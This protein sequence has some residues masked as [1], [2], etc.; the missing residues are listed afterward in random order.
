MQTLWEGGD[1]VI[2]SSQQLNSPFLNSFIYTEKSTYSAK[3]L[4]CT[5]NWSKFS[6]ATYLKGRQEIPYQPNFD[7]LG[8]FLSL[9]G[10]DFPG[11]VFARY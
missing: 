8:P 7:T 2:Q 9:K 5:T 3:L 10:D 4:Y 6:D 11:P 1:M